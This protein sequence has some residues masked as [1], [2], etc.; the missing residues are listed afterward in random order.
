MTPTNGSLDA[1]RHSP[2]PLDYLR[3]FRIPNV[4][5]AISNVTMGFLFA[6]HSLSPSRSP[7]AAFACLLTSGSCLYIAGMIL[8]DVYD[9][10]IDRRERPQRPLPAGK[11]SLEQAQYLGYGLL[12][13]GVAAGWLAGSIP[14]F[15]DTLPWRPGAIASILAGSVVL[16]DRLLKNTLLGPLSMG[17]CR[18]WNV[19]LGMS[20]AAPVVNSWNVAGYGWHHLAAAG[21]IAIYIVGVT[22]FSRTEATESNR[23]QLILAAAVIFGGLVLLALLQRIIRVTAPDFPLRVKDE[24][25]WWLLILASAVTI[26]R[27]CSMA[28]L[29]P[30]PQHVQATV[31]HCI[32]SLI[33]LDAAIAL[34]VAS[35][36]YA[37]GIVLLLVPTLLLGRYVYST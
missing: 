18:F 6:H 31:K 30:T 9:I 20:L 21:G 10:E 37:I 13:S 19:L 5:T 24:L 15:P 26:L 27:R 17:A 14:A 2:S 7:S 35:F 23:L 12:L 1:A 25:Y 3:L 22:W 32:L 16:Y 33:V 8:N 34:N 28:I 11:I 36:E 4:F 29:A